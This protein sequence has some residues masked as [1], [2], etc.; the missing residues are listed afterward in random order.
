MDCVS[1]QK[2]DQEIQKQMEAFLL[3]LK[4]ERALSSHTTDAYRR[5]LKQWLASSCDLTPAGVERYLMH[6][7]GQ[8]LAPASVARKRAALSSFCRYLFGEGALDSNPVAL[9]DGATRPG[10]KLPHVLTGGEVA[11]LLNAPNERTAK[12]RRDRA[13]LEM[14]YASG[15]RV[16]EV[17]RLRVGDVDHRRGLVRVKGKG[18]KERIVPVARH[19]L[20]ALASHQDKRANVSNFGYLFPAPGNGAKP[21]GR[22]MIWR[23]VKDHVRSAGLSELP[24]P[25]WL[26][27]SFATHLLNGGADVRVIQEMLGHAQIA[28]TQIYT[29]VAEDRLRT[30][31][32]A[33]HPRA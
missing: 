5:D 24:S 7:R 10:R 23:A 31:Y 16:S 29:H 30:A 19:A 8:K 26:R 32:R 9:V 27:H 14:M 25:H 2:P 3:H 1:P 18:G 4:G 21:L 15:L 12:G 33:A 6:L 28:T 11:R 22:G 17:A 13:L 20:A